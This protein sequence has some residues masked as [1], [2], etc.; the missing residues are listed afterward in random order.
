MKKQILLIA[1][2]AF[3]GFVS[4]SQ[5]KSSGSVIYEEKI[6]LEIKLDGEMAAMM[7]DLP[8][9][10]SSEKILWFSP[11][12]SL[13][14]N[15]EKEGDNAQVSGVWH[16][17]GNVN[18]VM[19]EPDNK[20]YIDLQKKK[21]IEQREFMTRMFLIEGNMP[22]EEWKITSQQEMILDNPCIEATLTDTS[23]VVTRIWFTPLLNIPA[24]PG[25]FCNL[26]GLVLKVDIDNGKRVL[27]AKNISF[28]VPVDDVFK[29]PGKGKKVSR[30]EFNAIVAEKMEEMGAEGGQGSGGTVVVRIRK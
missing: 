3:F 7:K 24:G 20:I 17:E 28:D 27:E 5:D 9:E 30:E 15:H 23:G 25:Q 11:E 14:E 18:I 26:P 1:F 6:Q 16:G 8:K 12:A 19:Q 22:D 29:K 10:R 13:Y 2:T 4:Y 21:I